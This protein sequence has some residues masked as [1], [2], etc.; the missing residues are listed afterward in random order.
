MEKRTAFL[1]AEITKTKK[2]RILCSAFHVQR[3]NRVQKDSNALPREE[4]DRAVPYNR[5]T[6]S[7]FKI[8]SFTESSL[9]YFKRGP[10]AFY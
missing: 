2:S 7:I 9:G 4:L 10:T 3:V 1:P 6:C 8:E 5:A